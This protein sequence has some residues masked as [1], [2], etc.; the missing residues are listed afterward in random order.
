MTREPDLW[1]VIPAAGVG[2]RL[3]GDKPKQYFKVLDKTILEYSLAPFC[4][5]PL[6]KGIAVAVAQEDQYWPALDIS[7]HNKITTAPGGKERCVS[8]LNGLERINEFAHEDDW[9][10]VHDAA[11]PCVTTDDIDLLISSIKNH[12][13]GGILATPVED[14]IKKTEL[15]NEISRTIDR[16]G[17][18]HALTPQMFR[19][20]LLRESITAA[21]ADNIMVT[22]EAQAVENNGYKA[23]VVQAA[24]HN[25]K[26][27]HSE[28]LALA[29]FYLQNKRTPQ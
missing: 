20:G 2:R 19:L 9:V 25:I 4:R 22:D 23:E 26:I 28:D 10:L 6:I 21:L 18:W 14:T 7:D 12:P 1:V 8:V 5:H 27:T 17:L 3:G 29:E 11:R 24:S 16:D 13:T 15:N